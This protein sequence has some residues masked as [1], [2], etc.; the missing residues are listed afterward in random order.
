MGS[1]LR[2][3]IWACV[4]VVCFGVVTF[5]PLASAQVSS[6]SHYSTPSTLAGPLRGG[7]DP[8][9]S[10]PLGL[11]DAWG[12]VPRE[13]GS[14]PLTP[15]LLQGIVPTIPNLRF[16]YVYNFGKNF[17]RG[18]LNADY[19]IPLGFDRE[20][21]FFGQAHFACQDFWKTIAGAANSRVDF[22]LGGGFR[23][24]YRERFMVGVNGFFD[25]TRLTG[26]WYR[27]SGAG[28]E[29][30]YN[31]TGSDFG[32]LSFNYYGDFFSGRTSIINAFR[33]G[34]ANFDLEAGYS[35]ALF[36][37]ALDLRLKFRGY[38]F[39][40]GTKVYGYAGGVDITTRDRVFRLTYEIAQD[41]LLGTY[42]TIAGL[43]TIGFDAS[44]LLNGQSPFAW[45]K[46][47]YS[48]PPNM[49]TEA[50]SEPV[51][52]TWTPADRIGRPECTELRTVASHTVTFPNAVAGFSDTQGFDVVDVG[53]LSTVGIE[54]NW[55]ATSPF[56][57]DES[58]IAV[59]LVNSGTAASVVVGTFDVIAD[60]SP[61]SVA[62]PVPGF[63]VD[64]LRLTRLGPAAPDI[65]IE[66]TWD[67]TLCFN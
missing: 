40:S 39:H 59:S 49:Y 18:S 13:S 22:S 64:Q 31:L 61:F 19:F 2:H 12:S 8:A 27:S 58:T 48:S 21:V 32:D 37:E 28:L 16:G 62:V 30:K 44:R 33:Y 47:I 9:P 66:M 60:S 57:P 24:V 38:Q 53:G 29:M 14:I 36:N 65:P 7:S 54:V 3:Q 25:A 41:D 1:P 52:R 51:K 23:K 4:V 34:P 10:H 26:R 11:R 20:N 55:S 6:R 63:N 46:P 5:A 67:A 17:R 35:H 15:R 56:P 45:P 50:T 43:V 42:H